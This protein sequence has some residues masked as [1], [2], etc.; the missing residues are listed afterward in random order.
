MERMIG[1]TTR[2]I[3]YAIQ[4][5]FKEGMI[6]VPSRTEYNNPHYHSDR[7]RNIMIIDPDWQFDGVQ[8]DLLNRI[9][10]RLKFEHNLDKYSNLRVNGTTIFIVDPK[11][12][13]DGIQ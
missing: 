8:R 5:L 3:D 6:F 10:K 9:K 2:T 12:V 4:V 13:V 7:N 11:I 1:K